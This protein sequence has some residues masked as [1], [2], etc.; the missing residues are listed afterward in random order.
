[1]EGQYFYDKISF[2][3]KTLDLLIEKFRQNILYN[4]K[5]KLGKACNKVPLVENFND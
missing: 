2:C 5:N 1:V 4:V 3:G